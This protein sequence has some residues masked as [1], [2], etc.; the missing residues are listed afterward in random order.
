MAE[1]RTAR[2]KGTVFF[3]LWSLVWSACAATEPPPP[4]RV[5]EVR[6]KVVRVESEQGLIAVGSDL[7]GVEQWFQLKPS[8]GVSGGDVSSVRTLKVGERVYVRYLRK[9]S[10]DPP[11]ALSITV[12]RYKLK[13]SGKGVGSFGIPGF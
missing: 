12:L 13:P 3:A 7:D 9:P 2:W 10:T 1:A 6:G 5:G 11:E 8:T 4:G